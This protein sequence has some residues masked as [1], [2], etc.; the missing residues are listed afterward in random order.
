MHKLDQ[1]VNHAISTGILIGGIGVALLV[2]FLS[3]QQAKVDAFM[4]NT[5]GTITIEQLNS[6]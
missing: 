1:T 6:F 5:S 2:W 3:Y 4:E